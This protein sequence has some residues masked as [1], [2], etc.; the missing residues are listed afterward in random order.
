MTNTNN[1]SVIRATP[2]PPDPSP[3]GVYERLSR[4]EAERA[5]MQQQITILEGQIAAY[6]DLSQ[7][8]T[9]LEGEL[10]ALRRWVTERSRP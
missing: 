2:P 3:H 6:T 1:S 10:A 9:R 4:L 7:R 5:A 8:L